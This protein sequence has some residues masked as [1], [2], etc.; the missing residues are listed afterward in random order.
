VEPATVYRIDHPGPWDK[1]WW[2][3]ALLARGVSATVV[4]VLAAL[5]LPEARALW[6][7]VWI[8]VFALSLGVRAFSAG[9]W[10]RRDETV[11]V[12]AELAARL[13]EDLA[14][15]RIGRAQRTL[16]AE[17]GASLFAAWQILNRLKA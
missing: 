12:P 9:K 6:P 10:G 1:R 7:L 14:E 3:T 13:R 16:Q 17:T 2:P 4:T 8:G 5:L 11:T 15:R